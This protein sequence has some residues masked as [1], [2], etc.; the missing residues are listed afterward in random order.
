MIAGEAIILE[1]AGE[2]PVMQGMALAW[3]QRPF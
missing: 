3:E 1:K 2:I